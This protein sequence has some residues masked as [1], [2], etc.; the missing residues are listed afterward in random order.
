MILTLC[1]T[2]L[3]PK[4]FDRQAAWLWQGYVVKSKLAEVG[5]TC[6][7]KGDA[8][9]KGEATIEKDEDKVKKNKSNVVNQTPIPGFF[10]CF[11][12]R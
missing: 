11:D 10:G 7:C 2:W 5:V 12:L 9:L 8:L 3:R 6:E 1:G 4:Q